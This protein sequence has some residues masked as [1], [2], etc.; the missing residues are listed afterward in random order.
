[1][2]KPER[3]LT[4]KEAAYRLSI[5]ERSVRRLIASGR[6]EALRVGWVI[7]IESDA[8]C[9]LIVPYNAENMT[10]YTKL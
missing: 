2:P 5:T 7:R 3:L 9:K 6:L 10:G 1:M 4:V 8:V